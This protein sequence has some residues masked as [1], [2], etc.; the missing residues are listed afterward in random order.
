[1][2]EDPKGKPHGL[3][4][5]CSSLTDQMTERPDAVSK[6]RLRL[7]V[8][9]DDLSIGLSPG[10]MLQGPLHNGR[11]YGTLQRAHQ[12]RRTGRSTD[13]RSGSDEASG[14]EHR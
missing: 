8:G 6:R 7:V 4:G 5:T 11:W 10:D 3:R 2:S 9:C 1:V 12:G 14:H 13:G